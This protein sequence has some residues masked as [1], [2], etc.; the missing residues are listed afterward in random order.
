MDYMDGRL[1]EA[2]LN[3]LHKHM[4]SCPQ[5]REDFELYIA[6]QDTLHEDMPKHAAPEGF[7]DAVMRRIAELPDEAGASNAG[8]VWGGAAAAALVLAPMLEGIPVVGGYVERA[9]AVAASIA[10][11]AGGTSVVLLEMLAQAQI[12]V[13]CIFVC[14]TLLQFAVYKQE[15]A[16]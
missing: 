16:W 13:L 5:C 6:I 8:Y 10:Y 11:A 4:E 9:G 12:V 3:M 15:K 7:D 14:L 1:G 2:Q